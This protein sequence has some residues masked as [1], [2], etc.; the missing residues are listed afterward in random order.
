LGILIFAPISYPIPGVDVFD[1]EDV[2]P[3]GLFYVNPLVLVLY[4]LVNWRAY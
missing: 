2:N 3:P 4:P 1:L